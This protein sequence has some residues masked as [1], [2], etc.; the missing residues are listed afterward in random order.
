MPPHPVESERTRAEVFNLRLEVTG[1]RQIKIA[2]RGGSSEIHECG[3]NHEESISRFE[4]M[5]RLE[6]GSNATDRSGGGNVG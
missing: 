1:E 6:P 5:G 3:P 4:R 2:N